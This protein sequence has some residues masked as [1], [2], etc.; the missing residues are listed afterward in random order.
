LSIHDIG[1]R[2]VWPFVVYSN[3]IW[4]PRHITHCVYLRVTSLD[5]RALSIKHLP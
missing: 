1:K 2:Y 5:V 4:P 3:P